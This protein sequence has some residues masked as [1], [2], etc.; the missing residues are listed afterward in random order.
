MTGDERIYPTQR[1]GT[2]LDAESTPTQ[3]IPLSEHIG[4]DKIPVWDTSALRD[5]MAADPLGRK[6]FATGSMDKAV[7]EFHPTSDGGTPRIT[8]VPPAF[9]KFLDGPFTINLEQRPELKIADTYPS[10]DDGGEKPDAW[11]RFTKQWLDHLKSVDVPP[12][13]YK[14]VLV[15]TLIQQRWSDKG[16]TLKIEGFTQCYPLSIDTLKYNAHTVLLET[17][18]VSSRRL[19]KKLLSRHTDDFVRGQLKQGIEDVQHIWLFEA[20]TVTPV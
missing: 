16:C 10:T 19:V 5:V 13:P 17:R 14:T 20:A 8:V 15:L 3:E 2:L 9:A 12:P 6:I 11:D 7:S 18:R 1:L 4:P